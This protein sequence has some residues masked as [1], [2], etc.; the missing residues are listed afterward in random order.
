MSVVVLDRVRQIYVS[1]L[2]SY[3]LNNNK[4]FTLPIYQE[5]Y[6]YSSTFRL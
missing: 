4:I 2:L 5:K 6:Q 3:D 1:E